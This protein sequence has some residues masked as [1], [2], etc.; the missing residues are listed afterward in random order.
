MFSHRTLHFENWVVGKSATQFLFFSEVVCVWLLAPCRHC[1]LKLSLGTSCCCCWFGFE[2]LLPLL[3]RLFRLLL[4]DLIERSE[5]IQ[6]MGSVAATSSSWKNSPLAFPSSSSSCNRNR[7]YNNTPC[8]TSPS[9]IKC[10]MKWVSASKEIGSNTPKD[11][12]KITCKKESSSSAELRTHRSL[13]HHLHLLLPLRHSHSFITHSSSSSSGKTKKKLPRQLVKT[14]FEVEDKEECASPPPS[15][16]PP[17][18]PPP[19]RPPFDL[20]LAVLLAG[21]AFEA[22]NTPKAKVGLCERNAGDYETIFLAKGQ[23]IHM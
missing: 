23:V 19:P 21:F 12:K 22:Y 4:T 15:P 13:H 11:G 7:F 14:R 6:R 20:D 10:L 2:I 17:P 16:P 5:K 9:S 8:S 18:P 1:S 3:L